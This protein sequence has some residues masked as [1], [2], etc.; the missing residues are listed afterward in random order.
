[1]SKIEE[2]LK[3]SSFAVYIGLVGSTKEIKFI[4]Y[5]PHVQSTCTP[6]LNFCM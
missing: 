4:T 2:R 3:V 1:M 5:K 6:S